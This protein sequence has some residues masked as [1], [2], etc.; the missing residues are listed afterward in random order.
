[1]AAA[2]QAHTGQP[3]APAAAPDNSA[4]QKANLDRI[5]GLVLELKV[6]LGRRTLPLRDLVELAD[7]SVIELDRRVQEP[8]GL[9][10]GGK[11]IARGEVVLSEGNYALRVTEI[12]DLQER[13][14]S[15]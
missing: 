12:C 8:A 5:L 2:P 13:L 4:L 14:E 10:L 11:V 15:V 7:G 9:L 3:T 6:Q 1:V